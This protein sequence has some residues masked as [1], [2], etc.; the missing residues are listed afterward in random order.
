MCD[1]HTWKD[2]HIVCHYKEVSNIHLF[3]A[4]THDEPN[5]VK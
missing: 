2:T 3:F 1:E 4:F 5:E